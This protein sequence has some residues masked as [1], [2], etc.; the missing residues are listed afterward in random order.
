MYEWIYVFQACNMNDAESIEVLFDYANG[1]AFNIR[2]KH[3]CDDYVVEWAGADNIA[4]EISNE[5]SI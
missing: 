1:E 5:F 3:S 2:A 4:E